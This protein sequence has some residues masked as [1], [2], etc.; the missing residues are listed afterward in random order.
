[1]RRQIRLALAG[2]RVGGGTFQ[3]RCGVDAGSAVVLGLDGVEVRVQHRLPHAAD[4]VGL[5]G[6]HA[7]D[8]V[9]G[10]REAHQLGDGRHQVDVQHVG[11]VD[12]ALGLTRCLD[13][14]RRPGDLLWLRLA[15]PPPRLAGGERLAVVA[16]H[17][18]ERAVVGVRLPQA[19]EQDAEGTVD[20]SELQQV[21]LAGDVHAGPVPEGPEEQAVVVLLDDLV[22]AAV[23]EDVVRVVRQDEVVEPQPRPVAG[24]EVLVLHPGEEL[25]EAVGLQGT[26]Q[27]LRPRRPLLLQAAPPPLDGVA[28]QRAQRPV[29][30]RRAQHLGAEAGELLDGLDVVGAAQEGEEVVGEVA[31]VRQRARVAR[32]PAREHRG[33]RLEGVR[34]VVVWL[35]YQ[36]VPSASAARFGNVGVDAPWPPSRLVVGSASST[37][38]TTGGRSPA[39]AGRAVSPSRTPAGPPPPTTSSPVGE[40]ARNWTRNPT[41]ATPRKRR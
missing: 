35:R 41:D 6:G 36:V 8:V 38:T 18:E 12:R 2:H 29:A 7:V 25:L 24:R 4:G 10:R 27:D 40:S 11:V 31:V 5:R 34:A 33:H 21:A 16:H 15:D 19:V 39:S 20:R 30:R 32:E 23:V 22:A 13:Q 28:E 1:M 26:G 9:P 3:L 37:T 14:Q 17:D